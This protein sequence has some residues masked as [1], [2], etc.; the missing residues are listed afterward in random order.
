VT[1]DEHRSPK[2]KVTHNV[3]RTAK[4]DVTCYVHISPKSKV[5]HNVH[6]LRKRT[7]GKPRSII[8]RFINYIYHESVFKPV[9]E[10]LKGKP[11]LSVH[12]QYPTEINTQNSVL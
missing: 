5:T 4:S 2:S 3:H 9:P 7:D 12:Q 11:Y 8:A 6:R 1:L 10:A